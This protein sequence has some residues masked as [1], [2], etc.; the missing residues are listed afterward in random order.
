MDSLGSEEEEEEEEEV[1]FLHLNG[2][3]VELTGKDVLP[4]KRVRFPSDGDRGSLCFCGTSL[5]LCARNIT[6][7]TITRRTVTVVQMISIKANLE[8]SDNQGMIL[9]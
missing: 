1:I 3:C 6:N 8:S 2:I 7:K 5:G 9:F 4:Q